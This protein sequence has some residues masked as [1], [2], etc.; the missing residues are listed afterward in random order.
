MKEHIDTITDLLLGAAYA[1]KRLEGRELDAIRS[2]LSTLLGTSSLPDAQEARIKA[3]NPAKHDA[4][5]A[6][7]SL[8]SLSEEDKG[9]LIDLVASVTE[10]DE[11]IDFAEDEYLRAVA[12]GLGL[13][14][15]EI[16][17]MTIEVLEEEE[18]GKLFS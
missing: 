10:S 5:A 14:E 9:K 6:A 18:I 1:D 8:A 13:S 3:F 15:D 4:A 16:A 2:M 11:E 7:A 12:T 17:G